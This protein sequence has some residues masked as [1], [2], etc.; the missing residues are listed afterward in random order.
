MKRKRSNFGEGHTF[1]LFR[2]VP[3]MAVMALALGG[4][5]SM[6]LSEPSVPGIS[7]VTSMFDKKQEPLPGRRI[8][9]IKAEEK[10]A[11]SAAESAGR[12]RCRLPSSMRRGAS[13]EARRQTRRA[14]FPSAK[15]HEPYGRSM[16]AKVPPSGSA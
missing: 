3:L 7:S 2:S 1:L 13:P 4:C 9:V 15:T 5:K 16:Q 8:S 12:S 6:G 14:I 11:V 10:G